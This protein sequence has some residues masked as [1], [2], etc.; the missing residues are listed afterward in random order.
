VA[1]TWGDLLPAIHGGHSSWR[2]APLH[3]TLPR[4]PPILIRPFLPESPMWQQKRAAGMPK[5]PSFRELFV[6]HLRRV[7]PLTTGLVA[8]RYTFS[9][10]MPQHVPRFL[11][12]RRG[13]KRAV[14]GQAA[15]LHDVA[16]YVPKL[17][18][19]Q[20]RCAEPAF[21]ALCG[22]SNHLAPSA[23]LPVQVSQISERLFDS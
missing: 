1:V 23:V 6:P 5:R 13:S 10:G 12:G 18:S 3:G 7:T 17:N 14:K 8:C 16:R 11:P 19:I 2:Y 20:V 22:C 4:H 15:F 21:C 9:F